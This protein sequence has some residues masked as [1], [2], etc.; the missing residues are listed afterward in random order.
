M[1][2]AMRV[3]GCPAHAP[4]LVGVVTGAM[5]PAQIDVSDPHGV[6]AQ[7]LVLALEISAFDEIRC[8]IERWHEHR[9]T[10]P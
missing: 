7:A 1:R 6:T 8:R 5:R 3:A 4:P 9:V 10:P 2:D